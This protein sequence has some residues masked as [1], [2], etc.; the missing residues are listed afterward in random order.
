[1]LCVR[2]SFLSFEEAPSAETSFR[3]ARSAE[4]PESP[5][6]DIRLAE[7]V[8][9]NSVIYSG[10][11]VEP[12]SPQGAKD[13]TKAK[14]GDAKK[15]SFSLK[16][17]QSTSSVSTMA[18]EDSDEGHGESHYHTGLCFQHQNVPKSLNLAAEFQK[19]TPEEPPTTMMIRNIPNR[20]SQR[21]L[22]AELEALGFAGSF[23]FFYAPIDSGTMGN[24][25]YAFVNFVDPYW[26]EH[27]QRTLTGY[28]FKKHQQKVRRKIAT[29]SVAHLQGLQANIRHYENAAVNGRNRSKCYG[30]VI[31]TAIASAMA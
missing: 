17:V 23:D 6:D 7:L 9:L 31:M 8:R 20:Y 26:A 4:E 22:I 19:A 14:D 5:P 10:A 18:P 25:G 15:A 3:R 21:E 27:C 30:P 29:V 1:M 13:S 24:V 12:L 2:N 16:Q 11:K 28:A